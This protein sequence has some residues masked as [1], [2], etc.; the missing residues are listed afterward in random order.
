MD[1]MNKEKIKQTKKK[2]AEEATAKLANDK[3]QREVPK[4]CP[5]CE[6]PR[7]DKTARNT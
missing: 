6:K 5:G 2:I 1:D 7:W 3:S 4:L